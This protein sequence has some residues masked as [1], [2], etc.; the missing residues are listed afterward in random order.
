M[1]PVKR[2]VDLVGPSSST[3][4]QTK[5]GM[6]GCAYFYIRYNIATG[7]RLWCPTSVFTY[8]VFNRKIVAFGI[9]F[10]K[11]IG[12]TLSDMFL[13]TRAVLSP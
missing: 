4:Y 1:K 10:V 13:F 7:L 11:G 12:T 2:I 3:A 8:V 5:P 9:F 6:L